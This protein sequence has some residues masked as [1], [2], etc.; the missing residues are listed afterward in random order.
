V[1]ASSH[2]CLSL[3]YAH[4]CSRKLTDADIMRRRSR[5]VRAGGSGA[6]A[7]AQAARLLG[8][9]QL[10][11]AE[12]ASKFFFKVAKEAESKGSTTSTKVALTGVLM[13][14]ARFLRPGALTLLA[15]L[16]I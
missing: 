5:W 7:G 2:S 8:R 11:E 3:A 4:V 1:D 9:N 12:N 6:E 16:L 13:A 14:L 15:L 10:S